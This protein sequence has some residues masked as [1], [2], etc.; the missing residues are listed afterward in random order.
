F[1]A[2]SAIGRSDG[3]PVLQVYWLAARAPG[4]SVENPRQTSAWRYP[5]EFGP[6][7]PTFARAMRGPTTAPQLPIS[8]TAAVVGHVS[9]H[10]GD[11]QAQ[12][13]ETFANLDS[14]LASAGNLPRFNGGSVLKTYVRHPQDLAP[15]SEALE[16]WL[17][18]EASRLVLLGDIC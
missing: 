6:T 18:A 12:L 5:R 4:Q 7:S 17:P 14:L 3:E 8:G 2:A 15:V 16:R 11:V 10:E 9:R 1:P 13:A